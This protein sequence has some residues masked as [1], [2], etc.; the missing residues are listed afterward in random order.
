MANARINLLKLN[1]V[2]LHQDL[3]LI[4]PTRGSINNNEAAKGPL[5]LQGDHGSVAFRKI[6]ITSLDTVN[7][8][9]KTN[10]N[11]QFEP[12]DPI[13]IN[14]GS[15]TLHRSFMDIGGK[16]RLTHTI[17]V[18]SPE[19]VHYTFDPMTGTVVQIWRGGFLRRN[20]DVARQGRWILSSIRRR[21][22]F[23]KT[24]AIS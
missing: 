12:V 15:T 11:P 10:N 18:G 7:N 1:G 9:P 19:A 5:R 16:Q 2:I 21:N 6:S 22:F 20:T 24:I 8:S 3:E 13:L 17:S 14:A 4:G 23:W